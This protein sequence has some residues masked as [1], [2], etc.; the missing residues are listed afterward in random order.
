MHGGKIEIHNMR[1]TKSIV[2]AF[3]LV[4]TVSHLVI[5]ILNSFTQLLLQKLCKLVLKLQESK[6]RNHAYLIMK[7]K[8]NV[9][10]AHCC[11]EI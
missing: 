10:K 8:E 2:N 11:H 6:E 4:R 5:S 7:K 1:W 3:A 9:S